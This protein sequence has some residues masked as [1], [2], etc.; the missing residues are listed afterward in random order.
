[1]MFGLNQTEIQN[2]YANAAANTY[3]P[4]R[5]NAP[6]FFEGSLTALP[7]GF[8]QGGA[9]IGELLTGGSQHSQDV[10]SSLRPDPM[11]TGWLGNVLQNI[12]S[13]ITPAVFGSLVAEGNPVGG[14]L[15]VGETKGYAKMK[16]LQA[17][18]VDEKTAA[19]TGTIEGITQGLGVLVPASATGKVV[20]RVATG[21]GIN[22]GIGGASRGATGSV[23]EA[24]GYKEM[25]DQYR[26]LDGMQI[27]TDAI[28]GGIFGGLN[29]EGARA[30]PLPSE[31]DAAL[32]ANNIHNHELDSAPGIPADIATRNAHAEAMDVATEQVL[33][34]EPVDVANTLTD[35]NFIPKPENTEGMATIDQALQENGLNTKYNVPNGWREIG[36]DEILQPG[37]T[38]RMD[39]ATGKNYVKEIVPS[40]NEQ[41]PSPSNLKFIEEDSAG[42]QYYVLDERGRDIGAMLVKE[43]DN[44]V[45]VR[46]AGAGDE[47][48]KG[49][50]YFSKAYKEMADEALSRGKQ[51]W[52]DQEVSASAAKIYSSLKKNGYTVI[53]DPAAGIDANGNLLSNNK[54]PVFKVTARPKDF[55]KNTIDK[56]QVSALSKQ[57]VAEKPDLKITD[58]SGNVMTAAEALAK[59][60]EELSQAQKDSNLFEVAANCF[61]RNS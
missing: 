50:G 12:G 18:G 41:T 38:I 29:V 54:N 56:N 4:E 10:V 47:S 7:A 14:A 1:M 19:E 11:T 42:K 5:D 30:D 27:F 21:A 28:L 36:E 25:A 34:G 44:A 2:G 24:N 53:K 15:T 51:L 57:I 59:A 33:R 49:K 43:S 9:E 22:V 8:E 55:A 6:G 17:R 52:S 26:V 60:D 39:M 32:A 3:I 23:L 31:I 45:T 13:V 58:E 61:L 37:L 16:E 48:V 46:R 20:T 35:T 40:L